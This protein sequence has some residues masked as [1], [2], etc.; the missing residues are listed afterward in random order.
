MPF[1]TPCRG[2]GAIN[3][4]REEEEGNALAVPLLHRGAPE[5]VMRPLVR[6]KAWKRYPWY[7]FYLFLAPW[8]IVGF[9]VLTV[10]PMGL[11][12]VVSFLSWDGQWGT[13]VH[14][15][16]LD[17]YLAAFGDPD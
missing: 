1:A 6:H 14:F 10:V 11:N 2:A 17:N 5:A 8:L 7:T 12:L 13:H 9:L 4:R 16:G 3:D 15:V